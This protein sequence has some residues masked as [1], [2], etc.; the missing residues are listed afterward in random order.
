MAASSERTLFGGLAGNAA[1]WDKIVKAY[2]K[3]GKR[4]AG[5]SVCM[6]V[7]LCVRVCVCVYT[8]VYKVALWAHVGPPTFASHCTAAMTLTCKHLTSFFCLFVF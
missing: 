2:E 5:N 7:Y 1:V 6:C 3:G 8:R 4:T